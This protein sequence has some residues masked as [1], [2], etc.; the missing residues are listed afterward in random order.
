VAALAAVAAPRPL[1]GWYYCRKHK[2][3]VWSFSGH[4]W[5]PVHSRYLSRIEVAFYPLRHSWSPRRWLQRLLW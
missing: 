2:C 4:F 5:C 1:E 3:P